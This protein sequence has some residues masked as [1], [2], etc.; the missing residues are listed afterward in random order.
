[1]RKIN[2]LLLVLTTVCLA[3]WMGMRKPYSPSDDLPLV[4][5]QAFDVAGI[6]DEDGESLAQKV[7]EWSGIT[8]TTFNPDSDLLVLSYNNEH[9][10]ATLLPKIQA[11]TSVAVS[12]KIFEKPAGPECPVPMSLIVAFPTY[13][14]WAGVFFS[15]KG[16]TML[17]SHKGMNI[18][19]AEFN[20]LVGDLVAALD[21]F[22]VPQKEKDELLAILGPMSTDIVGK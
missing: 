5:Y 3:G 8:A 10:E 1:M 20:A 2:L 14:F 22:K 17:E 11:C 13:L 12:K 4:T 16:K 15:Y 9:S 7:R 18:T 21:K 19:T 6:S